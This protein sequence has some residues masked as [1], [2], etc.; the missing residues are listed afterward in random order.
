MRMLKTASIA[1]DTSAFCLPAVA[2][3]TT[4]VPTWQKKARWRSQTPVS[5]AFSAN[6]REK[7]LPPWI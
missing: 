5:G 7:P 3:S 2:T 1:K 4:A 6:S